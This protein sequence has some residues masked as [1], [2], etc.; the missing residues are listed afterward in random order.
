[1]A[2]ECDRSNEH[3]R[4]CR[5]FMDTTTMSKGYWLK[6]EGTVVDNEKKVLISYSLPGLGFTCTKEV[7][8]EIAQLIT[9]AIEEGKNR[10]AQEIRYALGIEK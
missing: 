7:D 4:L 2:Y 5:N 9:V 1:M 6:I 10:K 8:Q 3:N